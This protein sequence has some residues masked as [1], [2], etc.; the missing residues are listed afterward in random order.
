MAKKKIVWIAHEGNKSGAN[1]ALLSYASLLKDKGYEMMI[2]V[3]SMGSMHSECLQRGLYVKQFY[4]YWII[5]SDKV[6]IYHWLKRRL[7]NGVLFHE[8]LT[9]Q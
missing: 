9:S 6:R 1:N 2:I 4:Y 3:P 5:Y 8:F 7:R